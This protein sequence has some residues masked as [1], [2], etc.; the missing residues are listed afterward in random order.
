MS[1]P[2]ELSMCPGCAGATFLR[3]DGGCDQCAV[4]GRG[5][6]ETVTCQCGFHWTT[7]DPTTCN[8]DI[9]VICAGCDR[10]WYGRIA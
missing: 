3:E 5:K 6:E 8:V 2:N 10:V 7:A 4:C 1:A 9:E